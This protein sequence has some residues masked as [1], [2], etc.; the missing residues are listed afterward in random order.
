MDIMKRLK[1]AVDKEGTQAVF[2]LLV[3]AEINYHTAQRLV[4]GN[5]PATPKKELMAKIEEA[6]K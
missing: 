4:T 3:K 5:Y 1:S 6:L 2:A